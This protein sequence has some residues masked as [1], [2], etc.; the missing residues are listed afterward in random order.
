ML[1]GPQLNH[2]HIDGTQHRSLIIE[3][4]DK[5]RDGCGRKNA[6][7]QSANQNRHDAISRVLAVQDSE[8][9]PNHGESTIFSLT[10]IFTET[11]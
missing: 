3:A 2:Y 9:G 11:L 6:N 10:M 5:F 4:M 7:N 1:V 8:R